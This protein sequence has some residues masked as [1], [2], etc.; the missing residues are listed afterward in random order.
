MTRSKETKKKSA[1]LKGMLKDVG[2]GEKEEK[3]EEEGGLVVRVDKQG[4]HR[5]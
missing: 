1:P 5:D 3:E 4:S 2:G